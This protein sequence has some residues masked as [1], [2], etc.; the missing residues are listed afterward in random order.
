MVR[1]TRNSAFPLVIRAE[2]SA[3]FASGYFS[4]IGR[5]PSIFANSSVFWESV[6]MRPSP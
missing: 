5:T 4:I 3:A 2:P 6:G 1:T